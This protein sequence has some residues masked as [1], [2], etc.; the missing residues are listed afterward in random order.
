MAGYLPFKKEA[1]KRLVLRNNMPVATT[2]FIENV[3]DVEIEDGAIII[4]SATVP[5]EVVDDTL[6]KLEYVENDISAKPSIFRRKKKEYDNPTLFFYY[7]VGL[8][9][10][11]SIRAWLSSGV[12]L[13]TQHK[14][15][16][17]LCLKLFSYL[18]PFITKNPYNFFE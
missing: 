13:Y 15:P 2:V 6:E 11:Q 7:V 1:P 9:I 3:V 8:D 17:S 12:I 18:N 16:V 10:F 14:R 4:A 5:T